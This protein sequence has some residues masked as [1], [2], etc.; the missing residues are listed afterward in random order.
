MTA[1]FCRLGERPLELPG[2]T[3][4]RDNGHALLILQIQVRFA[5]FEFFNFVF[6]AALVAPVEHV[7]ELAKHRIAIPSPQVRPVEFRLP[8]YLSPKR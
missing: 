4:R 6:D 7:V 1:Q 3:Q 5:V 8:F 2:H